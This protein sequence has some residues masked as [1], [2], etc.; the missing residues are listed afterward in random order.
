M[1][2]ILDGILMSNLVC[3]TAVFY[4]GARMYVLPNVGTLKRPEPEEGTRP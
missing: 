1:S 2:V 3:S 4:V